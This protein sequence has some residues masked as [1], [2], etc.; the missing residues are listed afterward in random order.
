MF[1][2]EGVTEDLAR[3]AFNLAHHKL[4][5]ATKLIQREAVL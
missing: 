4:P 1:E 3:T 2:I 5:I